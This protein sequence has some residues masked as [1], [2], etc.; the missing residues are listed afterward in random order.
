MRKESQEVIRFYNLIGRKVIFSFLFK[1]LLLT[2]IA[3]LFLAILTNI[4]WFKGMF[5][6]CF[7]AVVVMIIL[8]IGIDIIIRLLR[9]N[10]LQFP[11]TKKLYRL[12]PNEI[13]EVL[14]EDEVIHKEVLKALNSI[15][16]L[17]EHEND[18]YEATVKSHLEMWTFK[19]MAEY[20]ELF[21]NSLLTNNKTII[22]EYIEKQR[23][24]RDELYSLVG[25]IPNL[26][27][28]L[29]KHYFIMEHGLESLNN[30]TSVGT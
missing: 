23:N 13:L 27:T 28:I 12:S 8:N 16:Y 2:E 4:D 10:T 3:F 19:S 18:R 17:V 25:N 14:R 6:S 7:I 20:M 1:S 26:K 15:D 11:A 21:K 29:E 22:S 30:D 24:F 9:N 5:V